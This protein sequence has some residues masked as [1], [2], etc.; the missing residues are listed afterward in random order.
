MVQTDTDG[1]AARTLAEVI[2][3]NRIA[4]LLNVRIFT[5]RTH[6]IRVHLT[7]VGHPIAGDAKYGSVQFN[8]TVGSWGLKRLFLH[9]HQLG[10]NVADEP[11]NIVAP[12][13]PALSHVLQHL[14]LTLPAR[15]AR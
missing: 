2:D 5:G 10:F 6:Q 1:K 15:H 12:L 4:S 13:P 8:K 14:G 11:Y 7:S 3:N 9:A